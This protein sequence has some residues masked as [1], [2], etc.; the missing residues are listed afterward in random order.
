LGVGVE[1]VP[2]DIVVV[3]VDTGII[4]ELELEIIS[5]PL[6]VVV[7]VIVVTGGEPHEPSVTKISSSA[8]S[9]YG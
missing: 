9:P 7:V 6:V 2:G 8:M 4:V 1:F 5:G 3:V